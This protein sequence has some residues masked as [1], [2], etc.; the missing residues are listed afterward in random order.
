M[1]DH[2]NLWEFTKEELYQSAANEAKSVRY[3]L[4][5]YLKEIDRRE[6][7][8]LSNKMLLATA[9]GAIGAICSVIATLLN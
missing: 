4:H 7:N 9:L 1:K 2:N 3:S 5:D 6:N 8:A